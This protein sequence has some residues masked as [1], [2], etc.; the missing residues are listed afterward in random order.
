[1]KKSAK[2]IRGLFLLILGVSF[3][4]SYSSSKEKPELFQTKI[5]ATDSG[6]KLPEIR[7]VAVDSAGCPE[8]TKQYNKSA[9]A[10]TNDYAAAVEKASDEFKAGKISKAELQEKNAVARTNMNKAYNL[11]TTTYQDCCIGKKKKA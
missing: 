11:C 7:N 1:M 4:M 3:L 6:T 2:T 5:D 9:S 10:A 8:C